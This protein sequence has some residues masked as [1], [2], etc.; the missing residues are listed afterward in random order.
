MLKAAH[1]LARS[2]SS[3]DG[4]V[5]IECLMV[6]PLLILI[7][8]GILGLGRAYAQL[9][10]VSNSA[11]EVALSGAGNPEGPMGESAAAARN[12]LLGTLPFYSLIAAPA[13]G[14]PLYN[15]FPSEPLLDNTV[16]VRLNAELPLLFTRWVTNFQ[17]DTVLPILVLG[18]GNAG[19]L[20]QFQN[21]GCLYDCDGDKLMLSGG[22]C[23]TNPDDCS[24]TCS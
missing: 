12:T 3:S 23:C 1:N 10:W 20:T 17:V 5:I 19:N 7:F 21:A 11:Y 8:G 4:G 14:S 9:T 24:Q 6:I 18:Q 16:L 2:A 22:V 15:Q 13:I